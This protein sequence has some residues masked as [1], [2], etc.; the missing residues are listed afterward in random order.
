[1]ENQAATDVRNFIEDM[2]GGQFERKFALAL[3]QVAAAVMD[4]EK[5][6]NVK[7]DLKFKKIPGTGQVH[8]E[9]KLTYSR[10]TMDGK[11]SEEETRTTAFHVGRFGRLSLMP[12]NQAEIFTRAG[13]VAT[14]N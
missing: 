12:E 3:S 13:E 7:L 6:G 2:D 4:N 11:T 14:T 8:I 5:A 9:H 10:P 1:M